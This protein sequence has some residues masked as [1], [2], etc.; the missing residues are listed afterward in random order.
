MNIIQLFLINVVSIIKWA[1]LIRVILSWIRP[2]SFQNFTS[3]IHNITEPILKVLRG[4]LP[5]MGMIDLSPIIAFFVL[6]FVQIGLMKLF[7]GA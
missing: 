2:T 5:N 1:S 3:L 7:T 6:D 4:I